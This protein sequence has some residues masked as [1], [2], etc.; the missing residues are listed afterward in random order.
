[1]IWDL[2]RVKLGKVDRLATHFGDSAKPDLD[3]EEVLEKVTTKRKQRVRSHIQMRE[4]LEKGKAPPMPPLLEKMEVWQLCRCLEAIKHSGH[5]CPVTTPIFQ[6]WHCGKR[7]Y[8]TAAAYYCCRN[9]PKGKMIGLWGDRRAMIGNDGALRI[10]KGFSLHNDQGPA[11]VFPPERKL[12]SQFWFKGVPYDDL[13]EIK[14]IG[15]APQFRKKRKLDARSVRG[16]VPG[17]GPADSSGVGGHT[18]G[19]DS[20]GSTESGENG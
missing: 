7:R 9:R 16:N 2:G 5:K 6:C 19:L 15:K 3:D 20:C 14:S 4:F 8:T 17:T 12:K 1:M 11:V 10:Y 18:A 13:D